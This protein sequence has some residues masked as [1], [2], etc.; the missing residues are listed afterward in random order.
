MTT[1]T[2]TEAAGGSALAVWQAAAP[3]IPT[4]R[5]ALWRKLLGEKTPPDQ[6]LLAVALCARYDLDPALKHVIVASTKRGDRFVLISRDALIH[7]AHRSG[8]FDGL[9]VDE[10]RVEENAANGRK[11]WVTTARVWRKDMTHPFTA[12]GRYPVDGGNV[13]YGPEMAVKRAQA[14]ALRLAFPLIAEAGSGR[15]VAEDEDY[16][17][18]AFDHDADL[19]R[20]PGADPERAAGVDEQGWATDA[21][22]P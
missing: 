9:E 21:P 13:E 7:V 17:E 19:E 2:R 18:P 12:T 11:E 5:L 16:P 15:I 14:R 3:S 4:E 20:E 22:V 1:P 10:P 6:L 8:Q